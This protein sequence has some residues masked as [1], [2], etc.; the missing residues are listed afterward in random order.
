VISLFPEISHPLAGGIT[1]T[2]YD[3]L[4]VQLIREQLVSHRNSTFDDF[5]RSLPSVYPSNVLRALDVIAKTSKKARSIAAAVRRPSLVRSRSVAA[6]YLESVAH[7]LDYD[8]RFN[9]ET[10]RFLVR[11]AESVSS[12]TSIWIGLGTPSLFH[13]DV[14]SDAKRVRFLLDS[15]P[16]L[17]RL[18]QDM[19]RTEVRICDLLREPIPDI[20]G[21]LILL[22]PPWYYDEMAAF[23]WV[24]RQV[25]RPGAFVFLSVPQI[26][27][28]PGMK[29]ELERLAKWID[30]LGFRI[31]SFESN[32]LS[33][34][35]PL[36]EH[37]AL[38]EEGVMKYPSDWR[39]A[40]LLILR[41]SRS[42]KVSRPAV[43]FQ[44]KH[45]EEIEIGKVRV[46]IAQDKRRGYRSP[47]LRSLTENDHPVTVSRR[48]PRRQQAKIWTSNN[49]IFDTSSPRLVYDIARALA[50]RSSVAVSIEKRLGRR[51]VAEERKEI[52]IATRQI[53]KLFVREDVEIASAHDASSQKSIRNTNYGADS[54]DIALTD[55]IAAKIE[56]PREVGVHLAIFVEPFLKFVLEGRKTIESRFSLTRRA[57]F[58]QVQPGDVVILKRSGG[59]IVGV[60]RVAQT[61]FYVLDPKS[62]KH[63]R[64]EF[65]QR[66]C[67]EDPA[68]WSTRSCAKYA[69]LLRIENVRALQPFRV[70]KKDRRGWLVLRRPGEK[71]HAP[72]FKLLVGIAGLPGSGKTTV[73]RELRSCLKAD[74]IS[75]GDFFRV[76]AKGEDLQEFGAAYVQS[77]SAENIVDELLAFYEPRWDRPIVVEGIRHIAI[78]RALA[79]RAE[80]SQLVFLG[81]ERRILERRLA[82]RGGAAERRTTERFEHRV[83]AESPKLHAAANTVVRADDVGE[84]VA[85][86]MENLSTLL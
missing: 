68:F 51:L 40:D 62:W 38:E 1:Q 61:W 8:W 53:R 69:T 48:E 56:A 54:D 5:V 4:V 83:E 64:E 11:N 13:P 20:T 67:A 82:K 16:T 3:R 31:Q 28:R 84:A 25:C 7:P 74:V 77:R 66:L 23:L 72:R 43:Q 21:D 73:A 57:P 80:K 32:V 86:I 30:R 37:L 12:P 85:C 70:S 39:R 42:P 44:S 36:F 58:K 24:A 15:N 52:A 46:R 14:I 76:L 41:A 81:V 35:S 79:V 6:T 55:I 49:R 2:E 71:L 19:A 26:G 29:N 50:K 45:W 63:V 17:P 47:V 60:C 27:T 78:W 65:A 75:F 9:S 22:D 33:Y 34:D 18:F 10:V 59:P